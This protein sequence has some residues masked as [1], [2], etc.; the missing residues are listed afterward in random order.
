VFIAV[1]LVRWWIYDW[2]KGERVAVLLSGR[3]W[4]LVANDRVEYDVGRYCWLS[5]HPL[6]ST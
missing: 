6:A 4:G 1:L 2:G 3:G 5:V